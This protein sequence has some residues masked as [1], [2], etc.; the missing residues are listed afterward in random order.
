M[1][2]ETGM[3]VEKKWGR[4]S[5]LEGYGLECG[6]VVGVRW[7]REWGVVTVWWVW[8]LRREVWWGL[9]AWGGI[10]GRGT[11]FWGGWERVEGL[12]AWWCIMAGREKPEEGDGGYGGLE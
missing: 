5:V 1:G 10:K 12:W 8:W 6:G 7:R 11:V 2:I 9:T 3:E 4:V